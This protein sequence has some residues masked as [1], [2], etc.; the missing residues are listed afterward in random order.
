MGC[1]DSVR[2]VGDSDKAG[3]P[4]PYREREVGFPEVFGSVRVSVSAKMPAAGSSTDG[5]STIIGN[6]S[7]TADLE[8]SHRSYAPI[9]Q[10]TLARRLLTHCAQA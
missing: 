9:P 6:S 7:L 5:L 8:F 2:I 3:G 10:R 4:G 1:R